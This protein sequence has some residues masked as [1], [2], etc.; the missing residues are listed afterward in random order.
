MSLVIMMTFWSALLGDPSTAVDKH[1]IRVTDAA[2][3]P[4]MNEW[5]PRSVRGTRI[6][7]VGRS[8]YGWHPGRGDVSGHGRVQAV[9][10]RLG[11]PM[12][13][14]VYGTDMTGYLWRRRELDKR[15]AGII[16]YVDEVL[17]TV[18]LRD[19]SHLVHAKGYSGRVGVSGENE[20]YA[21]FK[22][23]TTP[24]DDPQTQA[25]SR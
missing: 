5:S 25:P 10:A 1:Y 9:I 8:K 7:L 4:D 6:S 23:L 21:W 11:P 16:V 15:H 18:Q 20:I 17:G 2:E 14:N 3:M 19:W 12:T 24:I 13:F 22:W